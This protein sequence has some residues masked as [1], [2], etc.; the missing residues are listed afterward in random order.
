VLVALAGETFQQLPIT[1]AGLVERP[2]E[3]P[4]VSNQGRQ[5]CA[6]HGEM[7]PWLVLPEGPEP[8]RYNGR[9]AGRSANI[10]RESADEDS[11]GQA[12]CPDA[13][14]CRTFPVIAGGDGRRTEVAFPLGMPARLSGPERGPTDRRWGP[15]GR[16]ASN[17]LAGR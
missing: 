1:Q 13:S 8:L 11:A 7:L 3:A 10:F 2:G 4:Q 17:C 5:R 9:R 15:W 6:C 12:P 14:S 16:P